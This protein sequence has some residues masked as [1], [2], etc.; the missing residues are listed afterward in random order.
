MKN[1]VDDLKLLSHSEISSIQPE[2]NVTAALW[3]PSS[4]IV[5]THALLLGFH[6]ELEK[7]GG[8]IAFNTKVFSIEAGQNGILVH[9]IEGEKNFSIEC[10]FLINSAGLWATEVALKIS[11]FPQEYIYDTRFA[12]GHYCSLAANHNFKHLIY[13]V[14]VKDG[15]GV[16]LTLDLGG[17]AKFGPDIY[18]CESIDYSMN[19]IDRLAFIQAIKRYW[20]S[21]SGDKLQVDYSGIRPKAFYKNKPV[22]D[23]V[24]S[25]PK[26]HG[27]PGLIN[28]YGIES[29]GLTSCL[30]IADTISQIF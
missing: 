30:S 21:M 6:G 5:D 28:L 19:D 17:K 9:T 3:S 24:I 1:G 10:D 25:T 8:F 29:P 22:N 16:H 2:L 23:F 4:G 13:P 11:N 18:W 12:K 14:P 15:L 7:Y 20:P 27:I 26:E